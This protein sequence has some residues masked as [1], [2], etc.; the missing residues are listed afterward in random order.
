MDGSNELGAR[1]MKEVPEGSTR[2]GIDR[3]RSMPCE[4]GKRIETT[5][6][7]TYTGTYTNP[8]HQA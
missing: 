7:D 3:A 1:Y 6:T 8:P 4:V 2:I 5:Y